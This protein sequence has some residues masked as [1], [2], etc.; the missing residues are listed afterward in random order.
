MGRPVVVEVLG[1]TLSVADSRP[2]ATP[3]ALVHPSAYGSHRYV[4]RLPGSDRRCEPCRLVAV[5]RRPPSADRC[6]FVHHPVFIIPRH[7]ARRAMAAVVGV[8]IYPFPRRQTDRTG[9]TRAPEQ[10]WKKQK[11][12]QCAIS[13]SACLSTRYSPKLRRES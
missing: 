5:V 10:P 4:C 11:Q 8:S 9:H 7:A 6:L 2:A 12:K 3:F 1:T 13:R